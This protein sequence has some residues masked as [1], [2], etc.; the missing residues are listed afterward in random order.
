MQEVFPSAVV[1][2]DLFHL[3]ARITGSVKRG[4][5]PNSK[6]RQFFRDVQDA[7]RCNSDMNRT[8]TDA[9]PSKEVLQSNLDQ[10][11]E[12]WVPVIPKKT[13]MAM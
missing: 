2:Q 12:K 7:F 13:K 1:K 10:L 5:M 3:N 4:E 8:R 6:K 9:V 11:S